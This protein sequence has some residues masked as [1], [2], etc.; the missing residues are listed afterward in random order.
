MPGHD[1]PSSHCSHVKPPARVLRKPCA[2]GKARDQARAL[3][4]SP[5]LNEEDSGGL[6]LCFTPS[7][8]ALKGTRKQDSRMVLPWLTV[9]GV[10][11]R[12]PQDHCRGFLSGTVLCLSDL[13]LHT[14]CSAEPAELSLG[15]F[16]LIKNSFSKNNFSKDKA[17]SD[18]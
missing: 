9:H 6:G 14:T 1:W 15:Y 5:H 4:E 12:P 18:P 13:A 7:V 2:L 10:G 3:W 8:M 11:L 16:A 17:A